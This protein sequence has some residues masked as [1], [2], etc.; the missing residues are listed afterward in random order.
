MC[1]CVCVFF[2][3]FV[4]RVPPDIV[5]TLDMPA[6][7]RQPLRFFLHVSS[8]TIHNQARYDY[9]LQDSPAL[10]S[11]PLLCG[12]QHN[13]YVDLGQFETEQEFSGISFSMRRIYTHM[14]IKYIHT[15]LLTTSR[16]QFIYYSSLIRQDRIV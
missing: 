13:Y 16:G 6:R 10:R 11:L 8:Q 2:S 15:Y 14:Y 7:I 3:V 12:G 9:Y 4:R 1:V 5:C